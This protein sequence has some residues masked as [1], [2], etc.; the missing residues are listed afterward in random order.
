MDKWTCFPGQEP[1]S[2]CKA[3]LALLAKVRSNAIDSMAHN[4]GSGK[5][6]P[7]KDPNIRMLA[8]EMARRLHVAG[9]Y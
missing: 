7:A 5:Q 3:V 1:T 9:L 2:A 4:D 8:N 6:D